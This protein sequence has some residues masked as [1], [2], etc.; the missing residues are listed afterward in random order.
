MI[1]EYLWIDFIEIIINNKFNNM[2]D[3]ADIL[4]I[5]N[6]GTEDKEQYQK[7]K[8]NTKPTGVSREVF[9]LLGDHALPPLVWFHM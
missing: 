6:I 7:K 4:G 5:K 3:V 1:I 9:S 2:G 8:K